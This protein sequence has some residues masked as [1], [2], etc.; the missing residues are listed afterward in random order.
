M[1]RQPTEWEKTFTNPVSDKGLI[2]KT[3]KEMIQLK[4]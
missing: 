4:T 1:R 2:C 3:Y